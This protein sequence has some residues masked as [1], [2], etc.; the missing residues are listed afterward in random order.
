[1]II[2]KMKNRVNEVL[3]RF[4]KDHG[5]KLVATNNTYYADKSDANAHD[6]FVVCKRR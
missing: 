4:S 3:I 5:V 1:M 6:I 2:K